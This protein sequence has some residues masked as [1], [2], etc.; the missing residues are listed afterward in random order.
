MSLERFIKFIKEGEPVAPGTPNRPLRQ[1]DQN[2]QYLWDVIQAAELGSTVYAREVTVESAVQLGMPVYWNDS[3]GQFER[4]VVGM[5]TD[6]TTGYLSQTD[7]SQVWGI[8]A[9]K[10]SA[11]SADLLLFGYANIDISAATGST[12]GVPA[13][14]Y[15]LSGTGLGKLTPQ[16]PPVSVPVLRADGNENVFVNPSF[17]D[18]LSNH[19]HYKFDL[20]M[21]PAGDVSP[22]AEGAIHTITNPDSDF[23]GWLPADDAIFESKAPTGAKFGYNISADYDLNN[24]WPPIPVQS[25][26]VEL[27]RP[28]IYD[29]ASLKLRE[30]LSG[31]VL[32]DIVK[33]DSNGIWWMTDCYDQVPWPTDY[34]TGDSLSYSTDTCPQESVPAM[35]L[36]FVKVNFATDITIV[37]SLKSLDDRLKIYCAGTTK[38]DSVGDLELDLDLNF[39]VGADDTAGYLAFKELDGSNFKRGPVAEGLWAGNSNV[40]LDGDASQ[41]VVIDGTARTVW[42]GNIKVSVLEAP[43]QELSSQLVRLDGVTEEHYPVLYLGFPSDIESSFIVKFEVPSDAPAENTKF[44]YRPRIIGRASGNLPDLSI[45]YQVAARPAAASEGDTGGSGTLVPTAAM[46]AMTVDTSFGGI[47]ANY[48]IEALTDDITVAPG[49][50]VYVKVTRVGDPTT[51]IISDGYSGELGIM[52]QNGILSST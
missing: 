3:E 15:Y 11:T 5:Q 10:H 4:A 26:D 30:K 2:V 22:P 27:I 52:Q 8:V 47:T 41:S 18:S 45:E 31:Q 40:L 28:S 43:T 51:G 33:L 29:S 12:G 35:L 6:A 7:S 48:A 17:V 20:V 37:R 38:I 39:V 49:D 23:T 34:T 24:L 14:T 25:A 36:Y 44:R 42:Y 19:Q 50:V 16:V 21:L 32:N 13:G 9:E 46:A 1:I